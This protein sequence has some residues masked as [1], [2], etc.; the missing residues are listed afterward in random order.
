[1][2]VLV[3]GFHPFRGAPSNPTMR[4]LERLPPSVGRVALETRVLPVDTE[5]VRPE[6]EAA[7]AAAPAAVVH[8]GVATVSDRIRLERRAENRLAFAVPDNRGRAPSDEPVEPGGPR[9]VESRLPHAAIV[10][11]WRAAQIPFACSESA[12]TFLCNQVLYS[13]LRAL[14]AHRLVGFIHVPPDEVLARKLGRVAEFP[15]AD[16]VHAVV[17][18][19]EAIVEALKTPGRKAPG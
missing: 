15:L 1:M 3:S 18:A 14:P 11:R 13:S 10:A 19:L 6:L 9:F 2:H 5:G 16:S 4:I 17:A 7:W 12:G 8:L